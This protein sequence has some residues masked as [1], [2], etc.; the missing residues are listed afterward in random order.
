MSAAASWVRLGPRWASG[1]R[2]FFGNDGGNS[3]S[4]AISDNAPA[5]IS[6]PAG[7]YSAPSAT[8]SGRGASGSV[9]GVLSRERLVVLDRL[10]FHSGWSYQPDSL[11][12]TSRTTR[13]RQAALKN[14]RWHNSRFW[15]ASARRDNP[16]SASPVTLLLRRVHGSFRLMQ[17]ATQVE[18]GL[19]RL[20]I[21]ISRTYRSSTFQ[22]LDRR[23]GKRRIDSWLQRRRRLPKGHADSRCS[24]SVLMEPPPPPP[25][26]LRRPPPP[27]PQQPLPI[28]QE[29]RIFLARERI[30][31][32]A[33]A[34]SFSWRELGL[35]RRSHPRH[36]RADA[37]ESSECRAK[38]R[39]NPAEDRASWP[40]AR[41][42]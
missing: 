24:H 27:A 11:P 4:G 38:S 13:R 19:S 22:S 36:A 39:R 7:R 37:H 30:R 14:F 28:I 42:S 8:T 32:S 40:R 21:G 10:L 12:G 33:K 2:H 16:T 31:Y 17:V 6:T 20:R 18:I 3:A 1:P 25:P 23:L 29:H 26:R 5:K 34:A 15:I 41:S 9:M 35:Y